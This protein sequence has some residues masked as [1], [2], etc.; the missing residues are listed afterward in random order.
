MILNLRPQSQALMTTVLE[1]FEERFNETE[2]EELIRV[3]GD[4]L[5]REEVVE[6]DEEMVNGHGQV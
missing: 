2:Q 4:V 3:V 1:D 5:G 6:E